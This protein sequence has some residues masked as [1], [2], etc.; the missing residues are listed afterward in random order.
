MTR[1]ISCLVLLVATGLATG[2]YNTKNVQSGGLKCA[3]GRACP[4][5][6]YCDQGD[7]RCY[8]NGT[9]GSNICKASEA[10][11]PFGPLPACSA[12][13]SVDECDPVCQSG[14]PCNQRCQLD[15]DPTAG[16]GFVCL[17]PPTGAFLD[18]FKACDTSNNLCKPG[19]DCFLPPSDSVGCASQ[20][21]RY[22]RKD[23]DCPQSSRCAFPVDNLGKQTVSVCSPPAVNCNPIL[24]TASPTCSTSLT[25]PNCYVFSHNQPDETM[26]DCGGTI[27]AGAACKDL[28]SCVAGHE[29][30][31]GKCQKMCSLQTG[32]VACASGQTCVA[33]H[34]TSTKYGT[35]K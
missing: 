8:R 18:D 21:I 1:L 13:G 3:P 7:N 29:C 6:F 28:H 17:A 4:D 23:D 10:Q 24:A 27:K 32:G 16:Y 20:C 14:C 9:A 22:C 12:T 25:G 15:G 11:P 30:V 35:C 2:C 31:D 19:L 33:L 34:G 5:G 26:C